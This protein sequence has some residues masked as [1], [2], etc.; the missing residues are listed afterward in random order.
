MRA[1][2]GFYFHFLLEGFKKIFLVF[3]YCY[4]LLIEFV[5]NIAAI[6]IWSLIKVNSILIFVAFAS[7]TFPINRLCWPIKILHQYW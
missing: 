5:Q 4:G 1:Q 7:F 2:F 6:S 3:P